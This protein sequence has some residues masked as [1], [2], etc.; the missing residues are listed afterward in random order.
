MVT[1]GLFVV[2]YSWFHIVCQ[3]VLLLSLAIVM[4]AMQRHGG[5]ATFTRLPLTINCGFLFNTAK[6]R[7]KVI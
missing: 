1:E 7:I 3:G 2:G 5:D 6:Q 4:V